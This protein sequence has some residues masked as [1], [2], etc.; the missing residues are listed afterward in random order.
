VS[1]T[2]R[3]SSNS[4]RRPCSAKSS[5]TLNVSGAI[6]VAMLDRI[7]L[8]LGLTALLLSIQSF[9][10]NQAASGTVQSPPQDLLLELKEP[11]HSQSP[12]R[13]VLKE[14][15]PI[16]DDSGENAPGE[17]VLCLYK[18]LGATCLSDQVTPLTPSTTPDPVGWEPHYALRADVVYPHGSGH[19]PLLLIVTGSLHSLNGNQLVCTQ[20]L[21]YRATQDEFRRIYDKCTGHNNN[22][23]VRFLADGP[24]RGSVISAEPQHSLPYGYWIE[25]NRLSHAGTYIRALRY[26]SAT[27]Y[28]DGNPLAVID[29][30]MPTIQKQLGVWKSG[31]P[32]PVPASTSNGKP[33]ANPTLRKSEL[34]CE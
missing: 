13:F 6:G 26:R 34:W 23:E 8:G 27:L 22:E 29:S 11:F 7:V 12:W 16:K 2:Y 14:E 31:D 21:A 19:A 3:V 28:A 15:T 17:L 18:G 9:A 25:V 1:S 10:Q 5:S 33:C 30:E 24:L 4:A 20:L 32:L